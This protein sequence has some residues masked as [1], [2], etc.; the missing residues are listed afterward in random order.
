M[1]RRIITACVAAG[2]VVALVGTFLPW[3]ASGDV[4]RSSYEL[5]GAVERLGFSPDGPIGIAVSAWPLVPL[6][7]VLSI[8]VAVVRARLPAALCLVLWGAAGIY[9]GGTALAMA[10]APEVGLVRARY[11]A[12]VSLVGAVVL[13]TGAVVEVV[14]DARPTRRVRSARL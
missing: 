12:W 4:D 5:V 14:T 2:A 1:R 11:G 8:V 9:V 7:L 13:L 3:L 6:L 10:T